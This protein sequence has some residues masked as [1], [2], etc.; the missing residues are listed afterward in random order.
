MASRG[1]DGE[2]LARAEGVAQLHRQLPN[3]AASQHGHPFPGTQLPT[4]DAM[5]GD[6]SQVEERALFRSHALRQWKDRLGRNHGEARVVG[7]GSNQLSPLQVLHGGT[8]LQHL[9]DKGVARI[10]GETLHRVG[11]YP[12]EG[13]LSARADSGDDGPEQDF[14]PGRSRD[15]EWDHPGVPGHIPLD[16]DTTIDRPQSPQSRGP[17]PRP[18][19]PGKAPVET[20]ADGSDGQGPSSAQHGCHNGVQC[21]ACSIRLFLPSG[22]VTQ[23][24][25]PL[26]QREKGQREIGRAHAILMCGPGQGTH[27]DAL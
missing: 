5:K 19:E 12:K 15:L 1:S 26:Y 17:H 9:S 6:D 24:W 10:L 22:P 8:Q 21:G 13:A 4:P 18:H 2:H 14:A 3:W 27:T 7:R 11:L 20:G 23:T 25:P 16:P